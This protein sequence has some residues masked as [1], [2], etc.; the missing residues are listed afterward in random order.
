ML[1]ALTRPARSVDLS[2]LDIRARSFTAAGVTF[3]AL[4]LSKQSRASKPVVDSFYPRFPEEEVICL[5]T[6]LQVYEARTVGFPALSTDK[7][8][9]L[10]FLSWIRECEP[11]TSCTIARWLRTCLSEADI[12]TGIFKARLVRRA[13]SSKAAG[14]G[15]TTADILQAADWSSVSMFQ[16]FYLRSTQES[17]NHPLFGKAV[18]A[19]VGA[20]N[21]HV[22]METKSSEM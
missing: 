21:L 17:K 20:S 12:D 7:T 6:T 2:K 3:K 22:D 16:K 1:L 10:V 18:L 14:I 5:V 4:H 9:T 11:V 13:A 19:S 8:K 15:V